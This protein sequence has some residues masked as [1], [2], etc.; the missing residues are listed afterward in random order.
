MSRG[1][2]LKRLKRRIC[3]LNYD[4]QK[5]IGFAA[6]SISGAVAVCPMAH[7]GGVPVALALPRGYNANSRTHGEPAGVSAN[8]WGWRGAAGCG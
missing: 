4:L 6:A 1:S 2:R 5:G 3:T 8:R 7:V